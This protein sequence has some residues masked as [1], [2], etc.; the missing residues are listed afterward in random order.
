MAL[1]ALHIHG[2]PHV[3]TQE[4]LA[5]PYFFSMILEYLASTAWPFCNEQDLAGLSVTT[6]WSILP[7]ITCPLPQ[8][9][10]V[11]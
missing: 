7:I 9:C 5:Q 1:L 4:H 2:E 11:R 8:Q 6:R 10:L 3:L